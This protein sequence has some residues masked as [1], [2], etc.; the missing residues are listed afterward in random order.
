MRPLGETTSIFV[1][2]IAMVFAMNGLFPKNHPGMTG[3]PDNPVRLR[4]SDIIRTA[5]SGL[6]FTKEGLPKTLL[7]FAVVGYN[8]YRNGVLVGHTHPEAE[9]L[10]RI[11]MVVCH[12][13]QSTPT[14]SLRMTLPEIY[15][16]KPQ[17]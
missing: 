15:P 5:W 4:L 10:H 12:P 7:F 6:S 8:I 9:L 2:I 13:A 11:Q 3:D 14:L 16:P 1:Q 17:A